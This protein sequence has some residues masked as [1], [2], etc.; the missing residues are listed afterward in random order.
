[1]TLNVTHPNGHVATASAEIADGYARKEKGAISLPAPPADLKP[2]SEPKLVPV[3]KGETERTAKRIAELE[4]TAEKQ[5]QAVETA[6]AN[7]SQIIADGGDDVAAREA[8]TGAKDDLDGTVDAL[9]MLDQKLVD[10]SQQE[11]E[12]AIAGLTIRTNNRYRELVGE[13]RKAVDQMQERIGKILGEHASGVSE[14]LTQVMT[15]ACWSAANASFTKDYLRFVPRRVKNA[16][17]R[18]EDGTVYVDPIHAR[19]FVK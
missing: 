19:G 12:A 14:T 10:V 9:R 15:G 2:E 8:L 6:K 5:R 11:W 1:M 4:E 13:T 18:N 7:L 3:E 17:R 16:P